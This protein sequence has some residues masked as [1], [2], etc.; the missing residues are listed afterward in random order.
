MSTT[1]PTAKSSL[2]RKVEF[3]VVGGLGAASSY[4]VLWITIGIFDMDPTLSYLLQ[5][6][7]SVEVNFLGNHFI[8]WR[9]RDLSLA[10][11]WVRFHGARVLLILPANQLMFALFNPMFGFLIANTLVLGISMFANWFINDRWAFTNRISRSAR[12]KLTAADTAD[13]Q[14]APAG[15]TVPVTGA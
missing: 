10:T 9:D 15:E 2:R 13:E 12:R 14:P 5:T 11:Q 3:A 6:V 4:L 7:I 8:T 1:A